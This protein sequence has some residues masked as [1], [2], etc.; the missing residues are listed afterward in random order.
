[1]PKAYILI[2]I[3]GS[4]KSTWI[5]QQP[6]EWDRTVIASSDSY[7]ER[8]AKEKGKTYSDVFKDYIRT[9]TSLMDADVKHAIENQLDIV[10]DQTNTTVGSRA[11]KLKLL[12]NNYEKIAVVFSTP[13]DR[14]L[15][16]R[17]ASRPGKTIPPE[18][19]ASMKSQLHEPLES[20]GFNKIIYVK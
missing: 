14:E 10:W 7:V 2:G 9:A 13:E 3:P 18:I 19:I 1:M 20:E 5:A 11:K 8:F 4:G 6:F 17:L 15:A 16:R 12:P